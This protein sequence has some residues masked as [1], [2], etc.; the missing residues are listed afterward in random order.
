[1]SVKVGFSYMIAV[2][3]AVTEKSPL[4]YMETML[5][6][7]MLQIAMVARMLSAV[8]LYDQFN[9]WTLFQQNKKCCSKHKKTTGFTFTKP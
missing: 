1:M 7:C 6:M 9:H 8:F 2:V 3:T 5:H 4:K